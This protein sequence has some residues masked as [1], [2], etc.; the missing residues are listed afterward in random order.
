[1]KK[2]LPAASGVAAFTMIMSAVVLGGCTG[3]GADEATRADEKAGG[4]ADKCLHIVYRAYTDMDD[5][6]YNHRLVAEVEGKEYTALEVDVDDL[7]RIVCV[8]DFDRDGKL[9]ALLS[10]FSGGNAA[11]PSYSFVSYDEDKDRFVQSDYFGCCSFWEIASREE[12]G[13]VVKVTDHDFLEDEQIDLLYQSFALDHGK[14]VKVEERRSERL[15]GTIKQL[16]PIDLGD[17][18]DTDP[19]TFT[20]DLNEDGEDEI[21]LC[22]RY[23]HFGLIIP[24]LEL[25]DEEQQLPWCDRVGILPTKTKGY[26]DLLLGATGIMVWDGQRYVD[27]V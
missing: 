13:V 9:D 21:F 18:H 3:Q 8:Q 15:G 27:K 20:F 12:E 16:V 17:D 7:F 5:A 4:S 10:H 6:Y 26:H 25:G 2:T 11:E 22:T 1:M 19:Y 14:A 23:H 24:V